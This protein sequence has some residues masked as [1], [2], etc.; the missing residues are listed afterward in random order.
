MT[1][2][3]TQR[4]K[5][6]ESLESQVDQSMSRTNMATKNPSSKDERTGLWGNLAFVSLSR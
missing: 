5:V 4:E 1:G 6:D 2:H 3:P